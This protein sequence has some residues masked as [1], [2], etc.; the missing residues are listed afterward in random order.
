MRRGSSAGGGAVTLRQ[1]FPY[2]HS[3]W[4][5]LPCHQE[6]PDQVPHHVMQEAAASDFINE[7]RPLAA[8][9]RRK[10]RPYIRRRNGF[11]IE[12]R[13]VCTGKSISTLG[14]DR[15]K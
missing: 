9:L 4:P 7:F 13:I 5:A 8:P 2:V 6:R 1:N 10:Y 11:T 14:I 15:G 12:F 3:N